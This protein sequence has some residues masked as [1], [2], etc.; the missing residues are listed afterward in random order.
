MPHNKSPLL[1]KTV[2][3]ATVTHSRPAA[4]AIA[5]PVLCSRSLRPD[6]RQFG[7]AMTRHNAAWLTGSVIGLI[8]FLSSFFFTT[9]KIPPMAMAVLSFFLIGKAG[10]NVW[11]EQRHKTLDAEE[12]LRRLEDHTSHEVEQLKKYIAELEH[13]AIQAKIDAVALHRTRDLEVARNFC[14]A[15]QVPRVCP[16]C[17]R[18][19]HSTLALEHGATSGLVAA[20]LGHGSFEI[21]QRHYVQP[22]TV[23]NLKQAKVSAALESPQPCAPA[24][25]FAL[26]GLLQKLSPEGASADPTHRRNISLDAPLSALSEPLP[27]AILK[28]PFL[29]GENQ[30][31]QSAVDRSSR[32]EAGSNFPWPLE[33]FGKS[34]PAGAS[35]AGT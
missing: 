7:D 30:T 12:A 32:R 1:V 13:P 25:S 16:H 27:N 18:G 3:P 11:R 14:K 8:S 10:F 6:L 17:L 35:W 34:S 29:D 22:D 28:G 23:D 2:N 33:R 21:T 9:T 15:A 20:A 26:V 19:L 24:D 5:N 4:A 31:H